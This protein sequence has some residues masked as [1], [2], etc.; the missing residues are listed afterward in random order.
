MLDALTSFAWVAVAAYG[1]WAC[2][3]VALRFV[4]LATPPVP[5]EDAPLIE[6]PADIEALAQQ[7]SALWAQ[8]DVRKAARERYDALRTSALSDVDRWNLVRKALGIGTR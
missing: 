8:D 7:E 2:R 4:A 3:D 1:V 6:I 5:V